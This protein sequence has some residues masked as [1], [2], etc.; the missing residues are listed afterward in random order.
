MVRV[1]PILFSKVASRILSPI[2]T[3]DV[4]IVR[5]PSTIIISAQWSPDGTML[6]VAGLQ[7]D[8][9]DAE[10]NVLHFISAYGARLQ[11]IRL[12]AG[13]F[14]GMA[15]ESS[16]HRIG[17]LIDTNIFLV[18]IKHSYKVSGRSKFTCEYFIRQYS[19]TILPSFLS[20]GLLRT[21]AR[22]FVYL[23]RYATGHS[24]VHLCTV[25]STK[26]IWF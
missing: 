3:G 6:A 11:I 12:T 26:V 19:H 10:R 2:F 25:Y 14:V 18:V 7:T 22:L 9:P 16:G 8:L 5:L 24:H 15:W 17:A 20:G 13:D 23:S 21:N 1:N 4:Y